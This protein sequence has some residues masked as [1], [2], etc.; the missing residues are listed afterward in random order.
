[1]T[2]RRRVIRILPANKARGGAVAC[3]SMC[4]GEKVRTRG[5]CDNDAV[6]VGDENVE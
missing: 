1:M 3:S 2:S 4:R 6:G 5:L